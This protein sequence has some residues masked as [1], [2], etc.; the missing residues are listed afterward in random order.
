MRKIL[1]TAL[2]CLTLTACLHTG[3][4]A[5]GPG[6]WQPLLPLQTAQEVTVSGRVV[7]ENGSG[8]PGVTVVLKGTTKGTTT[9]ATG[10]F[11]LPVPD[12]SGT[13]LFSFIGYTSQEVQINNR[14]TVNVSLAPDTKALEEVV[15]VGYGEQKKSVVTGA[16]SSVKASDLDNMPVTRVEQALQ[17][18]AS[19][20]TITSNSGQPGS[21]AT[22]R[23][24]GTTTIGKNPEDSDPLYVVDGVPI[25]GGIDY[26][27]QSDIA[28]IE[29]LKDAAS[30]AIYGTRAANGVILVTTKRGTS[31]KMQVSYNGYYGVQEPWRKLDLLNAREYATLYNEASVAGGGAIKYPNPQDLGEGTDWQEAVF[32]DNSPIQ[33]HELSVSGGGEKSTFYTSFGYFNQEGIVAPSNSQYERFT[34]RFNSTHKV[35]KA[36]TFGNNIGY[37]RISSVGVE[38]NSE[39]GAPLTRAIN[40]DPLTPLIETDPEKANASPYDKAVVRDPQG[41]P[42]GI[43]NNIS[44]E[45]VNP[46]AALLVDQRRGWSDKVVGNAFVEIEPLAGLRLRSSI[47]ADL[48]FWGDHNFSPVFYLNTTNNN[49]QNDY[50]RNNN[51]GLNWLWEATAAY[52]R[53][54]GRHNATLLVGTSAQ[55][56]KGETQG[57]T[58]SGIPVSH[59]DDAS[60]AFSVPTEDQFFWGGEYQNTLSSIFG[61][62]NYNY[63]ERYLLTGII[64]RDGSSKFGP[65][66]KYGVFPSV[67]V[68]WV[69]SRESFFPAN[70]IVNFLKIRGSYG[71][72]GNNRIDDFL[73]LARVG[74]GRNYTIGYGPDLELVNGV[75]PE[76]LSN[77]D[78]QWEETSQLNFGFEAVLFSDFTLTAEYYK[79]KTS[80]MLLQTTIPWYV[81]NNGPYGNIAEME[82]R[83]FEVELGYN[84]TIGQVAFSLNGN[85]SYLE[86]EVT[87]LGPE[88]E[89]LNRQVFGPSGE[90]ITRIEVGKPI[91]F[92][93]GLKNDGIFQNEEEIATY[94]NSEGEMLQPKAQ[95]GDFRRVDVNGDGVINSDDRTMIGDPTPDWTYGFT[96]SAKWK[97]FDLMVFGQG[98]AGNDVFQAIRRYDLQGANW[99]TEV[100]GRWAGEGTSNTFPRLSFND[101]NKNFSSS[102]D[103]YVKDGSYFRIKVL[104]LGYSLP[105]NLISKVGLSRLR[106]YVTGNNLFTFTNYTG[107]DPEI[108]GGS[109]G[110]DRGIYPQARAY[111]AG[112]NIGF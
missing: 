77:P 78:L 28:S 20:L 11:S 98:V 54:F 18:R 7:D 52:T 58:K 88:K 13:L 72:V 31:G 17:G 1:H 16:I 30:A 61:R 89:F 29:V 76:A 106:V 97:S 112:I 24:R 6:K 110:V 101:A 51:R 40:M 71:V 45:I 42:Y 81:G 68:G 62:V 70:D 55:K 84:K 63:D 47:G 92:L 66:N 65:N 3:A 64:R 94:V 26:L 10:N 86:N 15:V 108:G 59:L 25:D 91:N 43:S 14:A 74:G 111:M 23:V 79:K 67:S 21:P 49:T 83:G 103:F 5:A 8:L 53:S 104:Q 34:A 4:H 48:A 80:D 105:Q 39:W 95:P 57:G 69:T 99:T 44:S 46:V 87:S 9:D 37:T 2:G 75:S 12:G 82:N 109:F 100:F 56:N 107:Y 85:A 27:N 36:I 41:R 50:T 90:V 102:S 60:L 35:T 22:V 33:N 73:Y 19:G 96:A 93:Y 38:P 32:S